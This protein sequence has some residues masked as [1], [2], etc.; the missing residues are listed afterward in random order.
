MA[1]LLVGLASQTAYAQ[2]IS[3]RRILEVADLAGPVV[4]PDGRLVAFRLERASVERNTYDT[5]WYVQDVEGRTSARQVADGGAPL[6]NSAGVAVLPS[7]KWSADGRSIYFKALLDGRVAVWRAAADG[8]RSEPVTHDP[9]DVRDFSLTADGSALVYSVGATRDAVV[10][11]E[12]SEYER[13]VHIDEQSPLGQSLVRSGAVEGRAATQRYGGVWFDRVPLLADTPDRWKTVDLKT[14]QTGDAD[15]SERPVAPLTAVDLPQATPPAWVVAAEPSGERVAI[16]TRTAEATGLENRP[17]VRLAVLENRASTAPL[18]CSAD[19]CT[20]KAINRVQWRPNSDEILFT[21][22]SPLEGQAQ[23]IFSWNVRSGAVRDIAASTGLLAGDR[24]PSTACGVSAQALVCVG[25]EADRPPHLDTIDLD[26]G[27]RVTLFDP[28]A[29]LAADMAASTPARLLRWTDDKG[30]SFS[31][32]YFPARQTGSIR[33]PLFITYYY[34]PG[35]QRGGLGDEWPLAS[36]AEQ[37]I[38]ALCVNGAP[39]RTDAVERYDQGLSAVKSVIDLLASQGEIDRS[40]VGMG[41][42]SFGS[43]VTVWTLMKSDLLAAGSITSPLVSPTY[44]LLGSLKGDLFSQEL[45][46]TWQLGA[47]SETSD[48]WREISPTFNLDRIKAP[49]LM[50]TP[51]Q[52]YIH[53]LDYTI[54]LIRRR[55][56]DLYVFADEPHQKFQPRH[57]LAAYERNLDWFRFWLQGYEDTDPRKAEQYRHWREMRDARKLASNQSAAPMH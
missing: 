42:L 12:Q 16:L 28:N 35:F 38:A 44:Y 37:G 11:A 47:P 18:V 19:P 31:G 49:I 45:Q 10:A 33:P 34:C 8:S 4:S 39:F 27:R 54:P 51:E 24:W 32:Q 48:R 40:R 23:S 17:D 52:E 22:T 43:E 9:A 41:G 14:F 25:A 1:A 57:K 13:G 26:T 2:T 56:A 3:P 36:L 15:P 20:G 5:A 7:M 46:R 30:Q 55:Q 50:Q 29:G 6:R 53:G 21:V